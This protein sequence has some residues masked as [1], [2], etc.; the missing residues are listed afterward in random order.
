MRIVTYTMQIFHFRSFGFEITLM[1]K[2]KKKNR[3]F[4]NNIVRITSISNLFKRHIHKY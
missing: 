4:T 2:E 3:L 1:G